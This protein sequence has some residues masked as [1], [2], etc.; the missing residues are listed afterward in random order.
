MSDLVTIDGQQVVTSSRNVA[1]HFEKRHADVLETIEKLKTENSVL[2]K[3]FFETTYK[4]DGNNKSYKEYLMN[5][6]GFS[7]LVM[8]FTGA[9]ALGWKLKYIEAFNAMEAKLADRGK[10]SYMIADPVDRAKKWIEEEEV[11]QRQAAELEAAKPKIIFADAV[12]TS[13]T[14]IL[15][16]A[17][18]KLIKQ[19]GIDIGQ[20]RLFA[21]LRDND[22]LVKSGENKNMPTQRAMEM[23]LFEVK[24]SHFM[25]NNG[26]NK[27]TRTTKVTGK[28]QQYFINKFLA[29]KDGG[30]VQEG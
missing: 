3:M 5:R 26:T 19:N 13:K 11:R 1:E 21:W 12:A 14:C 10:D 17:L 16:G 28:G 27:T 4:V 22:Y 20:N 8:G 24:E 6:D 25:D 30:A 18:A 9:K 15:V 29:K 7:L 23:K 2:T